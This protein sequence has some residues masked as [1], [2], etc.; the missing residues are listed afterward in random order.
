M[1]RILLSSARVRS[2]IADAVTDSDVIMELRRRKIRYTV[3]T[4]GGALHIRVPVRSGVVRI[5]CGRH[6]SDAR[7]VPAV[8]WSA[9]PVPAYR[10]D[11]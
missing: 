7:P 3:T 10:N 4:A 5:Y 6:W 1:P 11:D 8:P 9:I 2:A